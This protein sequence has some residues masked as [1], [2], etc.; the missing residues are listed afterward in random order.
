MERNKCFSDR[1]ERCEGQENESKR[2]SLEALNLEHPLPLLLL[3]K[4]VMLNLASLFHLYSGLYQIKKLVN[5]FSTQK[6]GWEERDICIMALYRR[7]YNRWFIV[8]SHGCWK[9]E[10]GALALPIGWMALCVE[11]R[12]ELPVSLFLTRTMTSS[13]NGTEAVKWKSM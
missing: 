5:V 11:A 2:K 7:W 3:Y 12:P 1:N 4:P 9:A 8:I 13:C 10:R 6:G